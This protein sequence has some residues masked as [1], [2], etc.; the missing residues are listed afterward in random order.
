MLFNVSEFGISISVG[1]QPYLRESINLTHRSIPIAKLMRSRSVSERSVPCYQ[2]IDPCAAARSREVP[3]LV[4]SRFSGRETRPA[5]AAVGLKR[6]QDSGSQ[7]GGSLPD[8]ARQDSAPSRGTKIRVLAHF[9]RGFGGF[10]SRNE[11]KRTCVYTLAF[12]GGSGC[13][14][15]QIR[16]PLAPTT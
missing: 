8:Y 10:R 11:V 13:R 14:N 15:P 3:C 2:Q 12:N 7:P 5:R 1:N 6:R 9:L 4:L 16:V